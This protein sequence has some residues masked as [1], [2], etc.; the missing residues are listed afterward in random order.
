M[1]SIASPCAADRMRSYSRSPT[2][3]TGAD[4][5]QE[6][7]HPAR[8]VH[9]APGGSPRRHRGRCARGSASLHAVGQARAA[10]AA[11]VVAYVQ[12]EAIAG[13][14]ASAPRTGVG[15]NRE[16]GDEEQGGP[17]EFGSRHAP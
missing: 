14:V 13:T 5:A 3:S 4:A 7:P 2:K 15:P 9:K 11:A 6:C 10:S 12:D 16:R 17:E 1:D 8:R